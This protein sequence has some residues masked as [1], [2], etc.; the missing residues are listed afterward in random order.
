MLSASSFIFRRRLGTKYLVRTS[1]SAPA[2]CQTIDF[3]PPSLTISI[4]TAIAAVQSNKVYLPRAA[5][6]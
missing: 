3:R 5:N 6:G 1:G 4:A 2:S